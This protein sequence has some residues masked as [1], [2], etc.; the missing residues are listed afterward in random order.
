MGRVHDNLSSAS[1]FSGDELEAAFSEWDESAPL[2]P[3]AS[4]TTTRAD[5]LTTRAL[6]DT[7]RRHAP[8][9]LEEALTT[10]A[11]GLSALTDGWPE[12]AR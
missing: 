12:A 3:A 1:S 8:R 2:A 11:E 10:F 7:T 9:S 4:R 5:P 6:A